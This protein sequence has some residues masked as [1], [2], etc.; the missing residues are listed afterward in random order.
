[1]PRED[2]DRRSDRD[3]ILAPNEYAYLL[4]ETKG[5]VINYVGPHKTSLANTDQPVTFNDRT[6]RFETCTLQQAKQPFS[7]APEGWYLVLK[8]PAS[9]EEPP[10]IGTANNLPTLNIGRKVILPGPV[11]FAPWPGQ[12]VR[13]IK[14][15]NLRSNQYLV[16]RVYDEEAARA[17]WGQAV[18]KPQTTGASE[19]TEPAEAEIKPD[20]DDIPDLTIGKLFVIKG[21]E[22]SFYIPPTGIKVMRDMSAN[23]YIR[24]AVTLERLEYCILLDEDGNKRYIIGPDVVFPKPTEAFIEKNGARKFKAIELD[25]NS[26]I[27]IKVIAPYQ[28]G[29]KSYKVGD[30]LFVTGK[31]QMIYFPR[32]EHAIIRYGDQDVYHAAA[33]P[34]GEAMY[35]LNRLS[36]QITLQRGPSMFLPDPRTQVLVRR[37]LDSRQVELW[38]PGNQEALEY[39]MR[40]REMAQQKQ[41]D[42]YIPAQKAA[43]ALAEEAEI[44][45]PDFMREE[46]ADEGFVGDQFSR[47]FSFPRTITLDTKYEGAVAINIW[48]GYA[49]LVVSKTGE[50][51][52]IVGPKTYLLEYDETLETI[53]LSTGTPKSDDELMKTVY[54]RALHNKVS[55]VVEAES[56]DFC[57]VELHVSYR[58]NFED[59]P[60]NWYQVENYVKFLTD[61][62]RSILRNAIK[63]YGIENFYDKAID[64]VRDTV[65]GKIDES[66]QRVGRLFTENGMKIYDVEVLNITIEDKEIADLLVADQHSKVKQDLELAA[67]KRTQTVIEKKETIKQNIAKAESKTQQLLLDLELGE[68]NKRQEVDSAKIDIAL[69]TQ[70]KKLT[71]QLEEQTPL[72]TINTSTLSRQK[73]KSDLQ[74]SI[75][76]E[77]MK[78]RM[79]EL[80]AEVQ[81]VVDKA[82]AISPELIA[83]LQAFSDKALAE[84]MAESMAPLAILG[85]D[86]VADVFGQ[87]VK[88]TILERVLQAKTELEHET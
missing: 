88:G 35:V 37:V 3:L 42:E 31:D 22:V 26:G 11:S 71:G 30:E 9:D 75:A 64:I 52:V 24:N 39:N 21:T 72:D 77:Q 53:G 13:V 51:K 86:S 40:L 23:Q 16:V 34:A 55:D 62:M 19:K 47:S 82:G 78:H 10:R 12:M 85:G 84:K 6:K 8:N 36:G 79:Q 45:M 41:G 74:L 67:Q 18:M 73:A 70:Q 27:Y 32:P 44:E 80:N 50:R 48:T 38:F 56:N 5:N 63:G 20:V 57:K 61:H 7:I 4:D 29:E 66:G 76:E 25:E 54:L 49:M 43:F 1:M 60:N 87:L 59:D 46:S 28:N 58:V 15:H 65:L 17:N 2:R 33:I 69:A 68:V 81:A 14:G 83:A